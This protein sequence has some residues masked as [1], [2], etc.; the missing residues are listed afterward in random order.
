MCDPPLPRRLGDEKRGEFPTTGST[1]ERDENETIKRTD[2]SLAFKAVSRP[3]ASS[4][5]ARRKEKESP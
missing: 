1:N 4:A 3:Q 5:R 2:D